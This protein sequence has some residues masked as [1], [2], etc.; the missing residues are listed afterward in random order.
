MGKK[1]QIIKDFLFTSGILLICFLLNL[2]VQFFFKSATLVPMIF[3]L[4]VFFISTRTQG[5]F[6]GI[7]ASLSSVLVV[8]FVFTVPYYEID[9]DTT[10]CVFSAVV[11]LIVA[12]MTS[13][14]TTQI[15]M[16]EKI[17][18]E[19][20]KERMRANLLRAVS[21]DLRT[22]LTS[23]YGASSAIMENYDFL[24]KEQ[25]LKLLGEIHEDSQWLIRM[26]ENLLSVTRIDDGMTQVRKT[27]T[28][29]EELIDTVLVKFYKHHKNQEVLVEIPDEFV[30]IPMD[31]ML[32]EQVLINIL[33]NAVN[34][35]KGMTELWLRVHIENTKA[36]FAIS[37]NGC[38]IPKEKIGKLFTG[39]LDRENTPTDGSRNNMGIGLSVCSTIIKAHGS[40]IYVKN[41]EEGGTEFFFALEMEIEDEQQ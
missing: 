10:E 27:S 18:A 22:P 13:A 35:A 30:S 5:Y 33:E 7:T 21:H 23:I 25:Q 31:A 14:L 41:R 26:V 40:E 39:Y 4:G 19:S 3:V 29:L 36:I 6:W 37:D 2:F 11:M 16:Q 17:K 12:S 34:H 24:T 28:V 1:R 9:L 38:G 20:E 32:I 15:K 8:N